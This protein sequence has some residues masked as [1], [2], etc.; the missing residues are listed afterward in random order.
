MSMHADGNQDTLFNSDAVPHV[1]AWDISKDDETNELTFT[2]A[3]QTGF[4]DQQVDP[5]NPLLPHLVTNN[6]SENKKVISTLV[7]A[8]Q[9]CE[10]F[11][12]AVAF[13]AP[14]GIE[15]LMQPL[16][17]LEERGVPGRILTSTYLDFNDPDALERLSKFSNI[18]LRAYEGNLHT[19]GYFFTSDSL[20]TLVVGSSNLTQSALLA[21]SEWNLLVHSYPDGSVWKQASKEFERIWNSTSTKPVDEEWLKKYRASHKE[22]S[23]RVT[24]KPSQQETK[25]NEKEAKPVITP[26]LMQEEA[27]DNLRQLRLEGAKRAL[28][29]SATG[30][31]KTYLAALDVRTFDPKRAL[32]IIHRERIAQDALESFR[33]VIGDSKTY[34]I[35]SGSG[36]ATETDFVFAT[37]QSLVRHLD[38]FAPDAFDYIIVDEVHHS[39]ADSYQK[40]ID[41]FTPQFMLGMTATPNRGDNYDIYKLFDHNIAYNITLQDAQKYDLLAPFHYFGIQDLVV[42]GEQIEDKAEFSRLVS[43]DR[44]GHVI[45]Q[46]EKYSV[47]RERRG[48]IFCSRIDEAVE[49]AKQF[50]ARGV[51]AVALTGSSTDS[52]REDAIRRL[53]SDRDACDDWLEYIFTVDIFNEG[54]DIPSLNQIIML[55]PTESAIIFV[56]QLGRG[57]RKFPNK[58]YVLVLDFIGNYQQNFLIPVALSGDRS[59]DKDNLRRYVSEGN[60]LLAGCSTIYFDKVTEQ[61]IYR[62]LDASKFG[63][64]QH[65]KKEYAN[66]KN[67]LG[68]IPSL[69]DFIHTGSIDPQLIFNAQRNGRYLGSYHAFLSAYEPDYEFKGA[70]TQEQEQILA[71]VSMRLASGKRPHELMLLQSLINSADKASYDIAAFR[72]S[73]RQLSSTLPVAEESAANSFSG[74]FFEKKGA[75]EGE[76]VRIEDDRFVASE[77][78][79]K[80]LRN[81]E[82]KRQLLEVVDFGLYKYLAEYSNNY[83]S[84]SFVYGKK[85]SYEQVCQLLGWSKN[86][87]AQSIGGYKYDEETNTHPVFINY[88]KGEEISDTIR[89]HDRFVSPSKLIAISKNRRTLES[90]DLRRIRNSKKAG[91][92]FYL[93]VRKNKDDEEAKDFYFLGEMFPTGNYHPIVMENTNE[94]AVEIEYE[95]ETP[96]PNELFDYITSAEV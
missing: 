74:S 3:L 90:K 6:P 61:Q 88:E 77:T 96:V 29:I 60:K 84:T 59:G 91:T 30:T 20:Q 11:D 57:L 5:N 12:F 32:F 33:T 45:S 78:L 28:L 79:I 92:K 62:S 70:F 22:G 83:D 4:I 25:D 72:R 14:S 81:E 66:L 44:V 31:G 10:R 56:Q 35:Y 39:G 93:F 27:L 85:Y 26:N 51:R 37:I 43:N 16:L 49:L 38:D 40:V 1:E 36:R 64:I 58:D 68:H 80:A 75:Y 89:Y 86:V 23:Y 55:R 53:E 41:Y 19:K 69:L 50:R 2:R 73:I 95:L 82:F 24:S 8:M 52:D 54:I 76:L 13:I 48:L 46:I 63:S 67:M 7:N 9:A 87:T 17:E 42:D 18:E 15:S 21:N 94:N 71:L 47:E 65:L 34:G